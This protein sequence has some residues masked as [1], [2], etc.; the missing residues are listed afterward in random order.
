MTTGQMTTWRERLLAL[1]DRLKDVQ[2]EVDPVEACK[3]MQREFG[4]EFP[5]PEKKE[6]AEPKR[7]AVTSSGVS[8]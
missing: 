6:T 4:D 3:T 5:V 7:R 1:Q 8:A 2:N